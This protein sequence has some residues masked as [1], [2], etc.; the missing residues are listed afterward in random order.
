M[1]VRW[2]GHRRRLRHA[3]DEDGYGLF[4]NGQPILEVDYKYENLRE[5]PWIGKSKRFLTSKSIPGLSR[6]YQFGPAAGSFTV[7]MTEEDWA[8]VQQAWVG[9]PVH[10]IP[11]VVVGEDDDGGQRGAEE[12]AFALAIP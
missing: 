12:R 8:L 10:P 1:R 3:T 11:F 9:S 6:D 7:E 4:E 5:I 2:V